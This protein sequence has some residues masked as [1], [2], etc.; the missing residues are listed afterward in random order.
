[1]KLHTLLDLRGSIPT[2]IHISDGKMHDVNVLDLL[3]IEAGAFYIMDRGY[4]D[5]ERLYALDQ[6]GG[7]FITRAKRNLDAR[8]V[9]SAPV[10]RDTG[11][12]SGASFILPPKPVRRI[13]GFLLHRSFVQNPLQRPCEGLSLRVRTLAANTPRPVV[14][15]K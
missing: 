11:L 8:R 2:F 10:D 12:I 14:T 1:V 4:L 5:F 7:F 3:L 6:A 13:P 15:I 9:Y